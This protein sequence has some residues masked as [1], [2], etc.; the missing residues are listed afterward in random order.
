MNK[1]IGLGRL[2]KD[3]EIRIAPSGTTVA[4]FTLAVNRRFKKDG[5]PDADFINCVAFGE[6][7]NFFEK[8]IKKGQQIAVIGRLQVRSYEDKDGVK[9]WSTD[10][11]IEE[12]YFA[13]KKTDNGAEKKQ[14]LYP[15]DESAEDELPF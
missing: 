2:V 7:A 13:D 4:S 10:V 11:I 12:Q 1:W 5:D 9:R 6:K 8:Y 15:I 3:P 14:D